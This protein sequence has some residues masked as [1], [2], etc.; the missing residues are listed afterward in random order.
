MSK[1][2]IIFRREYAQVVKKKSFAIGLVLTPVLMSAVIVLP[3]LLGSMKSDKTEALAVIDQSGMGIG[4]QFARSLDEYKIEDKEDVPYYAVS[5]VIEISATDTAG[6][7]QVSDSLSNLVAEKELK[8]FF[9]LEPDAHLSDSNVYVVTNSQNFTSQKRFERNLSRLLTTTRLETS[10]VNLPIDSLLTLTR[11][12]D[13]I[14]RDTQGESMPFITKYFGALI[15]VMILFATILG[16]GQLVMRSV[17]E[18]KNSRIMEVMV[19]SVSPFQLMMG[20]IAGLGGA[21]LTQVA[22]W[23]AMGAGLFFLR[24]SFE[25]DQSIERIMF[26]PAIIVFFVLFMV[27]GYMLFST[28]FALV[29]SIVNSDKEAQGFVAPI[30]ILMLLPV[31]LGISVVQDPNSTLAHVLSLVPFTAPSMM[32]MRLVFIAPS[33]TEYSLFSGILAEASLAFLSVTAAFAVMVWL[34]GKVFRVGILMYGKRPT[35]PEIIKWVKY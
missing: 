31:F 19:S 35:L 12:I 9:V 28:L 17:I 29:G 32:M 11:T 26:N 20:K 15:F 3:A 8:Y 33:M 21:T 30:T 13:L 25:I 18:E 23:F 27:S 22:A 16:Y 6:F 1:F 4:K 2:L 34:T 10:E 14:S 7:A 5:E 24:S